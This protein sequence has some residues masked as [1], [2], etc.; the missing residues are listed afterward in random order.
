MN[1]ASNTSPEEPV[2]VPIT[3]LYEYYGDESRRA[4]FLR[5]LFDRSACDYDRI[6]RML[7]LGSG[8]WYRR[9]ALRRAGL[10]HGMRVVDVGF[11]TGL[12]AAQAITLIGDAALLTGVD[13]SV[14][15][16]QASP[17]AAHVRLVQGHAESIPLPD[18]SADFVS[19]GYALR[20]VSDMG[21]AFAEFSRILKPGGTVCVLELTKPR[22]RVGSA[23]LRTWMRGAVP[24]MA[25]L[26]RGS[27]A[28]PHIWR[29]YWDSIAACAP[30]Q[31]IL[32]T[33]RAVGLESGQRHVELGFCSEYRARKPL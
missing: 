11:G 15:M 13:P 14:G 19:M 29:Y 32:D 31:R 30:P 2:H 20:H 16:M 23:L 28:T 22:S 10:Q 26:T 25:C 12:L 27:H 3:P 18:A 5:D 9:Q 8:R 24:L 21:A 6:E 7:A 33:L 1:P 17:L 4:S